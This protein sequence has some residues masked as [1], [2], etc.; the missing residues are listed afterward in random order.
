MEKPRKFVLVVLAVVHL[1]LAVM[2][3]INQVQG[4]QTHT[5]PDTSNVDSNSSGVVARQVDAAPAV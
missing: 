2:V 5:D 3:L 1:A 4:D